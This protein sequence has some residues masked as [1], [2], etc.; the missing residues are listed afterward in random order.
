MVISDSN[1]FQ[2]QYPVSLHLYNVV[3]SLIYLYIFWQCSF[4][5][6]LADC[7]ASFLSKPFSFPWSFYFFPL[8]TNMLGLSLIPVGNKLQSHAD[9]CLQ[10]KI[11]TPSKRFELL[12]CELTHFQKTCRPE[13]KKAFDFQGKSLVTVSCLGLRQEAGGWFERN[14]C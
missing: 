5:C 4:K 6:Y 1:T 14:N 11:S 8:P 13:L 9:S 2:M 12:Q 10:T 7:F 3:V